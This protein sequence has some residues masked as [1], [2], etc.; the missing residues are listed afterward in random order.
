MDGIVIP[1]QTREGDDVR[2][3]DRPSRSFEALPRLEF[4]EQSTHYSFPLRVVPKFDSVEE[5]V[6]AWPVLPGANP[7]C[8]FF[9]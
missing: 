8:E 3:G 5:Y 9:L 1:G 2:L 7:S 4:A 6:M